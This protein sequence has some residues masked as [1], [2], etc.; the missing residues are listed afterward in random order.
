MHAMLR[1]K[2]RHQNTGRY[3]PHNFCSHFQT[4]RILSDLL[5]KT[6]TRD[7][8][9]TAVGAPGAVCAGKCDNTRCLPCRETRRGPR[10]PRPAHG[11]RGDPLCPGLSRK[12][13]CGV[14]FALP[15][16]PQETSG[17]EFKLEMSSGCHA[18]RRQRSHTEPGGRHQPCHKLSHCTDVEMWKVFLRRE[19]VRSTFQHAKN[20]DKTSGDQAGCR[21][22]RL[23]S[24]PGK[25]WGLGLRG[26]GVVPW[27]ERTPV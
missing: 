3:E 2:T 1:K 24:S 15:V 20:N 19:E 22:P 10:M 23:S 13:C 27:S 16:R 8:S 9:V 26:L 6:I 25:P 17:R 14:W 18:L 12:T 21:G 11:V 5:R 7:G 4:N